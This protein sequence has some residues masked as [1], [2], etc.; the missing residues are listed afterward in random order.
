LSG[1][2]DVAPAIITFTPKQLGE[3]QARYGYPPLR[4]RVCGGSFDSND[5]GQAVA[6]YVNRGNPIGGLTLAQ[7]DA[8]F[9]ITRKRGLSDISNWGQLGL[10]GDWAARPITLY[11]S[12]VPSQS[13]NGLRDPVLLH[14][15]FKPT[16][17]ERAQASDGETLAQIVAAVAADPGAIAFANFGRPDPRVRAVPLAESPAAPFVPGNQDTVRDRTYPLARFGY[18]YI[19][20]RP[21]QPLPPALREFLHLVLS[22]EGQAVVPTDGTSMP[23]PPRIVWEERA[24]IE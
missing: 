21:G 16:I 20:R 15:D 4:I 13:A 10:T 14:G 17:R 18:F 6:I 1:A 9:S 19:N 23:L 8:I 2:A 24:K 5:G 22:A 3:F 7:I 11:G 12:K